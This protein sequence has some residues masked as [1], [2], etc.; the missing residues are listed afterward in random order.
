VRYYVDNPDEKPK[1]VVTISKP[2]AV[3]KLHVTVDQFAAFARETGYADH[4]GCDWRKPGFPQEG[5]H[6]VVC[7]SWSD[8][9]AYV[10]WLAKKTGKPYRL[11]SEAEWEYAARSRTSPGYYPAF[12]FGGDGDGSGT[13]RYA[14]F[15]GRGL[16]LAPVPCSDG[17][18]HTSPAGRFEPN[19][20]G[21]YDMAGNAWQ[22]TGDCYHDR[23]DGAPADGSAW[24]GSCSSHV[25][26]GGS[27]F[28]SLGDLRT[29]KRYKDSSE[30]SNSG[31]RVARALAP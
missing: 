20:F 23:Y 24:T 2:F 4:P 28:S 18:S 29:A 5:S 30:N 11:L 21:L 7:V 16:N 10:D 14:N 27:W 25:V 31:F 9:K 22:W 8:A 17:Y 19:A 3:G 6:P 26:R 13:C 15:S 1:H 12:W